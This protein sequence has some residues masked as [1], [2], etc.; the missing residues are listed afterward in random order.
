MWSKR[1]L[2]PVEKNAVNPP[3]VDSDKIYLPPLHINNFIKGMARTGKGYTYLKNKFTRLSD[4]KKKVFLLD[5]RL[6]S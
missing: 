4:A 6:R 5:H 1:S 2:T 3:L